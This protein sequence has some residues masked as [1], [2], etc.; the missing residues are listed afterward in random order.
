MPSVK[1]TKTLKKELKLF[2]VYAIA[3][4][5]T[6]SGG[7]FLLPGLAAIQAGQA[8]VL[9]Y[10]IA[11][12]PLIPAVF[13][14]IELATAMPRAGGM[15]Y[16]LDRTLGPAFGTI[17]GLGTWL[18]LLLK[19]AF[20]LIGIGAYLDLF[21]PNI[22]IIPI[23]IAIS[24]LI[25]I[26]NLFG[27][28]KSGSFQIALVIGLLI[29]LVF[30]SIGGIINIQPD[31][32]NGFFDVEFSSILST[33]GLVYI[34]YVGITK[35]ASL[36]EEV[37]NPERNIPLGVFLSLITTTLIYTVGT[38]IM[39][40]VL[41]LE[42]L[43]G[44]LTPVASSAKVFY[45]EMGL[46]LLSVAAIMAF[47]SVSNAGILSASRYPLAMSRDHILPKYF[48]KLNKNRIPVVAIIITVVLIILVLLFF[49]PT[50]IAKLASSFQLLMFALACFAVIVMRES[51]IQSYDPGYK[52]PL[53]PWMQIFGIIAPMV[54]I[55]EMGWVPILFTIGLVITGLLWYKYYAKEKV[56]RSGAIFHVF[57]RLGQQRYEGL[58]S[59]LRGILKEKGLRKEDPFDE[60]VT[61]SITMDLKKLSEFED[62][63]TNVSKL[64]SEVIPFKPEEISAQIMEG[65]RIG[66]TPVTR[67]VALP[68][69]RTQGIN[70]AVMVLVRS[71]Q[72]VNIKVYNPL[73][74]QEE[75][76]ETVNAIFFLISPEDNPSQHL[77]ILAQIAGRVDDEDFMQEWHEAKNEQELKEA[78]LHNERFL[79]LVIDKSNKAFQLVGKALKEITLPKDS[80]VAL[81]SRDGNMIIPK[82]D[83]ILKLD[84]RLTIIGNPKSINE[85]RKTFFL[86]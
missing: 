24:I 39:V 84:D 8:I 61:R 79:S 80:L 1:K 29:L 65:T 40:G 52:S 27:S 16:F 47:I 33:A 25:G 86:E 66:A 26:V 78:L 14:I 13:S 44:N 45:G 73:T 2:D 37:K 31:H 38:I 19:V 57:E 43:K 10:I 72:G 70:E 42:E 6:L 63:V 56:I 71:I 15:Y 67:G 11:A 7:L 51:H 76:T 60:I 41:P 34:S 9:A 17:G 58:D 23:A 20:A 68:H 74:Q 62:V 12:I 46:I 30:Y 69:F 59:E 50:R 28:K 81:I 82:G 22:P 4:G 49:D 21:L 5:T 75:N 48:R 83:T 18:A 64:L 35:V 32:F 36:S 55:F 53:Y 85:I 3:T 77:R 54:L